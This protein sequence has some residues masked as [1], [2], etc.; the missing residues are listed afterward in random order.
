[1]PRPS[2]INPRTRGGSNASNVMSSRLGFASSV[3]STSG[4]Q[5]QTGAL[6]SYEA[7]L[8]GG[9]KRK[10]TL[11]RRKDANLDKLLAMILQ[12]HLKQKLAATYY[13][14]RK[15]RHRQHGS[16]FCTFSPSTNGAVFLALDFDFTVTYIA[17]PR[18]SFKQIYVNLSNNPTPS[19]LSR[20]LIHIFC[21]RPQ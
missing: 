15:E 16:I 17:I 4:D 10:E 1:M 18:L 14:V 20:L 6:A 13:Q 2:F 7:L 12:E 3:R 5:F 9:D 21:S 19:I 8:A 11:V